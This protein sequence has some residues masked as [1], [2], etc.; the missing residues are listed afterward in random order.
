MRILYRINNPERGPVP[1]RRVW[2]RQISL[3]PQ[4]RLT[5]TESSVQ[6]LLPIRQILLGALGAIRTRST[7]VDVETEVV[8]STGAD[9]CVS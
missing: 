5:L 4:Y 7:S 6:H 1:D 3:Y 9:V 2:M 8:W